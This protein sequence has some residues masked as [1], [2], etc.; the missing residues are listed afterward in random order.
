M[1]RWVTVALLLWQVT[2]PA[3]VR[4]RFTS[5]AGGGEATPAFIQSEEAENAQREQQQQTLQITLP[6]VQPGSLL[7][8]AVR[9][10]GG[11]H[12]S[13]TSDPVETWT[14]DAYWNTATGSSFSISMLSAH[15]VTGG[16]TTITVDSGTLDWVRVGAMEYSGVATSS[17]A[18]DWS[19]AGNVGA[20]T[21]M[22]DSGDVTT[23]GPNRLLVCA[24]ATDTD[25]GD[26]TL[27]VAQDG[28]ALRLNLPFAFDKLQTQDR[29]AATA[30]TYDGRMQHSTP[31]GDGW[32]A[33]LVAYKPG[34]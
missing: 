15:N 23:L 34:S 12:I 8:V 24:V 16:T 11:F 1:R 29:V 22:A 7:V 4:Q 18:E 17:P 21:T 10:S 2:V 6:N 30:G 33:V 32:M 13:A 27:Y 9:S 3:Q 28:Y 25:I 19:G 31:G 26:G 20:G 14:E 5:A